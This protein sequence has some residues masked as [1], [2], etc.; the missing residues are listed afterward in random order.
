M[1]INGID[2]TDF[3]TAMLATGLLRG[4][5]GF[6]GVTVTDALDTPALPRFRQLG[7]IANL[8]EGWLAPSAYGG[9]P[10]YDYARSTAAGPIG[11]WLGGR[12]TPYRDIVDAGARIASGS[13]WFYTDENPWNDLEAGTTSMDPGGPNRQPMLPNYTVD[14]ARLLA[15]RTTGSA[16]QVGREADLGMIRTGYR[17]DLVVVDRDPLTVAPQ[18]LHDMR[19]DM[20]LFAGRVIFSR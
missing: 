16:Y 9:P 3:L 15:A 6:R 4:E 18:T 14:V 20:T 10:G 13:D 11:P 7:V 8:Q 17:A 19:V 5:L 1:T 2:L 12:V